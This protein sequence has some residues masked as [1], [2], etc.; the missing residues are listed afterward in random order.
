MKNK[1]IENIKKGLIFLETAKDDLKHSKLMFK[2]NEYSQTVYY[3]Q[4][5][6]E[7]V[8]KALGIGLGIITE[9]DARRRLSHN[10]FKFTK[11]LFE[12][13]NT[14]ANKDTEFENDMI[15]FYNSNFKDD[16]EK[17]NSKLK[18]FD[19]T[20]TIEMLNIL[21]FTNVATLKKELLILLEKQFNNWL[22][23]MLIIEGIFAINFIK[24]NIKYILDYISLNFVATVTSYHNQTT[25]YPS[26]IKGESM[27]PNE[28]YTKDNLI[29]KNFDLFYNTIVSSIESVDITLNGNNSILK[30]IN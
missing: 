7:K 16:F 11:V 8:L 22:I 17:L 21:K 10:M 5:S 19:D 23:S 4:Q 25:R 27:K 13:L 9:E 18:E 24:E 20:M 29:I 12:N 15:S 26:Y 28:L 1:R 14:S 30:T 6:S 3:L 2:K